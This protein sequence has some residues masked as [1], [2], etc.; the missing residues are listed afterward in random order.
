MLGVTAEQRADAASLRLRCCA[1]GSLAV[2]RAWGSEVAAAPA[3]AAQAA[4]VRPA[5]APAGGGGGAA[6]AGWPESD[7][8]RQLDGGERRG[9]T[10]R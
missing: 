10:P 3:Q 8:F 5:M 9:L 6:E 7:W 4:G 2:E 1:T